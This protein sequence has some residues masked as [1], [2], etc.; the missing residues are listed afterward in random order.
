MSK[1]VAEKEARE[2]LVELID[3]VNETREEVLVTRDGKTVARLV[4]PIPLDEL[5]R[6]TLQQLRGSVKI[7]GDIVEPLED[8]W[9]CMK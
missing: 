3:E 6:P 9:D 8:E 7:L 2:H 1:S 5:R 4:P